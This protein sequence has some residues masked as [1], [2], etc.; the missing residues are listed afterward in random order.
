MHTVIF[1]GSPRKVGNTAYLVDALKGALPGEV[2][3]VDGWRR[4]IASC[5]DCRW[6]WKNPGCAIRDGM[7]QIYDLLQQCDSVVIA[8]P[9]YAASLPG[10]LLSLLSRTQTYYCARVF[11][12]EDPGLRPKIGATVL[13]GGGDGAADGAVLTA[14][15]LL[16]QMG[17][18][19]L[20]PAERFL[21]TNQGDVWD[22]CPD[23]ASRRMTALAQAIA[24]QIK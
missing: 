10:P 17:C 20:L 16:R 5:N 11:R 21:S 22:T 12:K 1:N 13:V 6:C 18:K 14:R 24:C 15:L 7:Q 19:T 23:E 4:D 9:V 8:A 3:I 2:T